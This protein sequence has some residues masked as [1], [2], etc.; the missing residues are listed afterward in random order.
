MMKVATRG[1]CELRL[2]CSLPPSHAGEVELRVKAE[3][4]KEVIGVKRMSINARSK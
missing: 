3:P 4:E 2:S 1:D